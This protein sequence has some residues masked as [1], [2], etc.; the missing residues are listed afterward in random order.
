MKHCDYKPD[1]FPNSGIFPEQG[2][3]VIGFLAVLL[4]RIPDNIGFFGL[5]S[6]LRRRPYDNFLF[7]PTKLLFSTVFLG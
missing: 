1:R 5:D 7:I 4:S 2:H 3:Q 6:L